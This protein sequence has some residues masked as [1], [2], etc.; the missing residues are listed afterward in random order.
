MTLVRYR[1][2]GGTLPVS[3]EVNQM[4]ESFFAGPG[5]RPVRRVAWSP[6]SDVRETETHFVVRAEVP[7]VG[8]DSITINLTNNTLVIKGEKKQELDETKGQWHHTERT[9]GSFERSITLPTRVNGEQITA[10]CIDG[11]LE[12]TIPKADEARPREIKIEA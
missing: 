9:W 3:E 10:R 8:K 7:G 6:P 4:L 1:P 12:I 2:F 11:V 5:A